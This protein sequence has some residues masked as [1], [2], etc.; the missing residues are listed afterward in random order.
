VAAGREFAA[1]WKAGEQPAEKG[2]SFEPFYVLLLDHAEAEKD[3]ALFEKALGV[4]KRVVGD[5]PR[6]A[7][8]FEKQDGRLKALK[9]GKPQ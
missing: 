3:P 8:F 5:N 7:P 1:I 2:P 4:L 6:A 9:E